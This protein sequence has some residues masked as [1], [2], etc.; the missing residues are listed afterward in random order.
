MS[1]FYVDIVLRPGRAQQQIA[2]MDKSLRGLDSTAEKLGRRMHR[3]FQVGVASLL[4][5]QL[6]SIT[7]AYTTMSN[8]VA[9]VTGS[10]DEQRAVMDELF[11]IANRA[12][13]PIEAV[14]TG[15]QR[16]RNATK[17]MGLS[18]RETLRVTE[19][20]SKGL[21]VYGST[22]SEA[23]STMTQFT[24]ALQSGKLNGDE[25]RSVMENS[26]AVIELL[27]RQL[28]ISKGELKDW[29]KKGKISADQMVK[30]LINGADE[31]DTKFAKLTPTIGQSLT[32]LR[33][34]MVRFVGEMI[35]GSG[36]AKAIATVIMFVGRNFD[37]FAK[38]LLSVTNVLGV[39]FVRK[40]VTAAI[41]ALRALSA[42]AL[43]NP[44]TAIVAAVVFLISLLVNFADKISLTR[45][46]TV[47][48]A[49]V[50]SAAW[51]EIKRAVT[52]AVTEMGRLFKEF[53]TFFDEAFK[54]LDIELGDVLVLVA[55]FVDKFILL[56]KYAYHSS[57]AILA[58]IPAAGGSLL[59]RGLS[60]MLEMAAQQINMFI[61]A[62]NKSVGRIAGKIGKVDFGASDL[63]KTADKMEKFAEDKFDDAKEALSKLIGGDIGPVQAAM[64]RI[65]ESAGK[66]GDGM[67][68]LD[69]KGKK[70]FGG[71]D[72]GAKKSKDAFDQLIEGLYPVVKA[73]NDVRDA[74]AILD[75]EL[76]K[77]IEDAVT[78]T[79]SDTIRNLSTL[80]QMYRDG[81]IS[82]SQYADELQKIADTTKRAATSRV[83]QEGANQIM[84]RQR[85]LAMETADAL[86][87]YALKAS[88]ALEAANQLATVQ[89]ALPATFQAEIE[90]RKELN[91]LIEKGVVLSDF[92]LAAREARGVDT[93]ADRQFR[94]SQLG[95]LRIAAGV[96]AEAAKIEEAA[97]ERNKRLAKALDDSRPSSERYVQRLQEISDWYAAGTISSQ[98][99]DQAVQALDKEF[100]LDR[101]P[102]EIDL[103]P[104]QRAM[105]E[106]QKSLDEMISGLY[107][108]QTV[109]SEVF[110][111]VNNGILDL[112]LEGDISFKSFEEGITNLVHSLL[113][114]LTKLILK[115]IETRIM[116]ALLGSVT[117][118][119]GPQFEQT[120]YGLQAVPKLL[121][122]AEGGSFVAGGQH[123]R[124]KN[125][126]M[127]K[128]SRGEEVTVRTPAQQRAARQAGDGPPPA[129]N[130]AVHNQLE[131]GQMVPVMDS[132]AGRR[133]TY[134]S[135]RFAPRAVQRLR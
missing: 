39:L 7:D 19:T 132:R 58:G 117:P 127:F 86:G 83:D 124:D 128:V 85:Y 134:N 67:T 11:G 94:E 69:K 96:Q 33:N 6:F 84:D 21:L 53:L 105:V 95:Q 3:L 59:L 28:K 106:M 8:R 114:T 97:I 103:T 76:T 126:A 25:F 102:L 100:S 73:M 64:M 63:W 43:A 60:A 99:F 74:R 107:L 75:K 50:V 52:S 123:G 4:L 37:V 36:A 125:V 116:M 129:V 15:Y 38:I 131:P 79:V 49:A 30:A 20:L 13:A 16:I 12:R 65:L 23:A 71:M 57:V 1:N 22:Q 41:G 77:G 47:K 72:D 88:E 80:A 2:A 110:E 70:T 54:D 5:E 9:A 89:D 17:D 90:A 32:V 81:A 120:P 101:P 31:I 34:N 56:M 27:T 40:G 51:A 62:Y 24:Q 26:P 48:L 92:E 66:A 115:I 14:T 108:F 35:T 10:L 130:V 42:A 104:A 82:A 121:G 118:G 61:S 119:V 68:D 109:A 135:I 93:T 87:F 133:A 78:M 91:K 98:M 111:S 113:G 55:I 45:D 44:F 18:Q 46:G 112:V 29:S 122:F